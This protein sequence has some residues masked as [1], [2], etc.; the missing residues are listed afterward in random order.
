MRADLECIRA[1]PDTEIDT[2]DP[3]APDHSAESGWV[4]GKFYRPL[5]KPISIRMDMDVLDWFR[6]QGQQYQ[7]LINKVL[8]GYMEA[9]RVPTKGQ[10]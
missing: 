7:V 3:D 8:R 10:G 5:K 9:K 2:S 6:S 1:L 4:R